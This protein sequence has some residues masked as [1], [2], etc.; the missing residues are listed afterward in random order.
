MGAAP[1][2]R[3]RMLKRACL[4]ALFFFVCAFTFFPRLSAPAKRSGPTHS[5]SNRKVGI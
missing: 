4:V 1:L 3:E 5:N 2:Y